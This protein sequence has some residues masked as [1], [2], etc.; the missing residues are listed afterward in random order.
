MENE[1]QKPNEN[2]VRQDLGETA[3]ENQHVD[4]P[5][6]GE[7]PADNLGVKS[8]ES[9]DPTNET[10]AEDIFQVPEANPP[11]IG[12][13]EDAGEPAEQLLPPATG[14]DEHKEA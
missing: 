1:N 4:Q 11:V 14:D 6:P 13:K 7:G 9:T 10:P 12:G 2:Q 5:M 3:L 8:P